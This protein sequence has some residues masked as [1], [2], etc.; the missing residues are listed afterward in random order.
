MSLSNIGNSV[1]GAKEIADIFNSMRSVQDMDILNAAGDTIKNIFESIDGDI[2][3]RELQKLGI[4]GDDLTHILVRCG[5]KSED[6]ADKIAQVGE[7]GVKPVGKLKSALS[8]LVT[9]FKST[10]GQVTIVIAGILALAKAYDYLTHA[11]DRAIDKH[12]ELSAAYKETTSEVEALEGDL[13]AA[14]ERLLELK[15]VDSPELVDQKEIQKLET[16]IA[17]METQLEIKRKLAEYQGAEAAKAAA[18]ALTARDMYF[19]GNTVFSADGLPMPEMGYRTILDEAEQYQRDIALVEQQIAYANA[20]LADLTPGT[21]EYAAQDAIVKGYEAQKL[22]IEGLLAELQQQIA[23]LYFDLINPDGTAKTGYEDLVG[24]IGFILEVGVDGNSV[25]KAKTEAQKAFEAI[26]K[27]VEE[28]KAELDA[29]NAATSEQGYSGNITPESYEALIAAS[30]DYADCIEYQNGALQLNT[31]KANKLFEA[32]NQLKIAEIELQKINEATKWHENAEAIAEYESQIDTLTDAQKE[33]LDNLRRENAQIET[34]IMGY[35]VQIA[36]LE[37]LTSAYTRWKNVSEAN[38]SDTMYGDMAAAMED[39]QGALDSGKTGIGN[40]V[41]QA[42]VELLVPDEANVS[43]YMDTL[44]RYITEDASG[45]SNFVTD[46]VSTGLM[47][48]AGDQVRLVAG[49][50]IEQIC[51]EMAITP[52]MA[53]AMFNA[54]EMYEGWDFDWT[55][56][57]FA[58]K[59]TVDTSDID[60][61]I[62]ALKQQIADITEGKPVELPAGESL[63]TLEAR[64]AELEAQKANLVSAEGSSPAENEI[65]YTINADTELANTALENIEA[66]LDEI[67]NKIIAV[68]EKSIGDLG[69][70]A[71]KS[72]LAQVYDQLVA[73]NNYTIANK[74]YTVTK[75]EQTISTGGNTGVKAKAKGTKRAAGGTA[76]LGDE[77]SPDGSPK[78]ELV[79]SDGEAYIAGQSGPELVTLD[80]GDQVLTASETRRVLRGNPNA[81]K[82]L[83][84]AYAAGIKDDLGGGKLKTA[85]Q[86]QAELEAARQATEAAKK[87]QQAATSMVQTAYSPSTYKVSGGGSPSSLKGG[88]SSGSGGGGGGSS[89][90]SNSSSS[91]SS[92]KEKSEFEKQYDEHQHLLAMEKERTADYLKWL[93]S[94]YKDAYAQGQI[95][96]E[97][98]YKYEEEVFDLKKDVFMD[99]LND[100]EHKISVLEREPGNEAKI[101]NLYN[102]MIVDLDRE[103]AAARARGLNDDDD[104]MQE[105]LDQKYDYAD[106]IKDIQDELNDNA[107]DALDDLVDYRIE[108]LKQ[109]IENEKDAIND[110]IDT[111]KDFYDKQKKMLQDVYDE[112]KYLEEQSEKRKTKEGIQA[113][114]DQL[115]FDDSAWAERR[116]L[117]L[118]EELLEAEKDLAD[119]EK[120]HAFENTQDLLDKM[121]EQQESQLQSQIDELD[122]KLNDPE[123]LY[124][125]ALRDIQNNTLALYEEMVEYN[126]R[127]GSGNSHDIYEKWSEADKSLDA[128]FRAMGHAYKNILLVDAIKPSGYASGTSHASAGLHE[129]FEGNKD[130]YIYTTSDG[131]RYRMFSGLG[132]K[133]LNAKATDFLYNFAN[134]GG[135]FIS[136]ILKSLVAT[137]AFGNISGRAQPIQLSTGDIII[138]GNA[139]ERTVSEIRRAQRENINYVLHEFNRLGR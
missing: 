24:R 47:E 45:L 135:A 137:P 36:T 93:E 69:G 10:A 127:Y 56:E 41:Y 106:E 62:A 59:P 68:A 4:T 103:I 32:K 96:L 77:Y 116:R 100:I 132:D 108:M 42:A 25:D 15:S 113:E 126:N 91:G 65:T 13:E 33:E 99:G 28:H 83:I 14:Q 51:E 60:A 110:K 30:S 61:Q 102:Q 6:V 87:T 79:I 27:T 38:N 44:K 53:K 17:L 85:A 40:V 97:D 122:A 92:T 112:E 39:I 12:S 54:L 46:M 82:G 88:S 16:S 73:I 49:T 20:V 120:D 129:L 119:F 104:Y 101:I 58:F 34:N 124:N 9:F 90:S 18:K 21:S 89:S 107:K 118:Q 52:E 123:A 105:L 63:S 5:I 128:Y 22:E 139:T 115:R 80:H 55:E 133:V 3:V 117:E 134:N 35:N 86:I 125:K 109:D 11:S 26:T 95:E 66:K 8:G 37:E 84:P 2:A 111:L 138:Q 121:Y 74:S 98:F 70:E 76:L 130:E 78:P 136:E 48:Q 31:E 131:K 71:A 1:K 114:I 72:I 75:Y 94:A 29:I 50:T 64:L 23:D 19:T 81:R 67:A 43:D 57:D 7:K